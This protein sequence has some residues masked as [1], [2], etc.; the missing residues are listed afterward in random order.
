[1]GAAGIFNVSVDALSPTL[2]AQHRLTAREKKN[3]RSQ[4]YFAAVWNHI[5]GL[6]NYC[7]IANIFFSIP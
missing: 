4:K 1:V 3:H 5:F 2:Q 7:M 6:K